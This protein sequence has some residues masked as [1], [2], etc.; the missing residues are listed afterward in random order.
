MF[1]MPPLDQF[2]VVRY[3]QDKANKMSTLKNLDFW[4]YMQKVLTKIGP[5]KGETQK[6]SVQCCLCNSVSA[7]P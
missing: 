4:T 1:K 3:L 7:H 2:H 5:F 6:Q